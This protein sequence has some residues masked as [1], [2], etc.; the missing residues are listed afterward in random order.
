MGFQGVSAWASLSECFEYNWNLACHCYPVAAGSGRP[1]QVE[2]ESETQ[3]N[4]P[5]MGLEPLMPSWEK[6]S[7]VSSLAQSDHIIYHPNR[8]RIKE[9]LLVIIP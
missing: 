1:G 5:P 8:S 3:G 9:E 4:R 2:G 6:P 7:S